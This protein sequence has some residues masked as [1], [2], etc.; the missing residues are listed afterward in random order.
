MLLGT[1]KTQTFINDGDH[2]HGQSIDRLKM[3]SKLNK[4]TK[5]KKT[6]LPQQQQQ[7]DLINEFFDYS[8]KIIIKFFLMDTFS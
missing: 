6:G 3:K 2:Y 7:Q 1:F 5:Q 8:T 4:L